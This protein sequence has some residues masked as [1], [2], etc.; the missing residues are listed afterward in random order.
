M[1]TNG[2]FNVPII[3]C[4]TLASGISF[5][6]QSSKASLKKRKNQAQQ[7]EVLTNEVDQEE[8]VSI[9]KIN[10]I[11]FLDESKELDEEVRTIVEG[12]F[13]DL[14]KQNEFQIAETMISGMPADLTEDDLGYTPLMYGVVNGKKS[15]VRKLIVHGAPIDQ[16]DNKGWTALMHAAV[17]GNAECVNILLKAN[18]CTSIRDNEGETVLGHVHQLIEDTTPEQE[19]WNARLHA[20]CVAFDAHETRA[21]SQ[22]L[23]SSS[24]KAKKE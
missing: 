1:K 16:T 20:V 23:S 22:A 2:I 5:G 18:A 3:L 24:K 8:G 14:L 17:S 11:S 15:F 4:V 10:Q 19:T 12:G 21:S 13:F 9:R 6:S 7:Y